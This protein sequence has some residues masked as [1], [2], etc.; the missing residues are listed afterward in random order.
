MSD[1]AQVQRLLIESALGTA[2]V[3]KDP[4]PAAH[5][6]K[7][8]ADGL[9]FQL[10]FWIEDPANGQ[11]NVKSDVN[12]RVLAALRGAGIDIPYPQRVVR[13]LDATSSAKEATG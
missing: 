5:F 3:L 1:P 6:T 7:F 11:T 2:R 4:E 9:E 13:V 10:V 12:L 8:G